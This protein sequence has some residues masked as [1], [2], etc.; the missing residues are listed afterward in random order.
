MSLQASPLNWEPPAAQELLRWP[1][2]YQSLVNRCLVRGVSV[3]ARGR[4]LAMSGLQHVR[5][6]LDPFILAVNHNTRTEA[7]L[8]PALIMLH[9][10]GRQ[11][12]FMAD[13]NFR[14]IPGIGLI[15]RR[16][17]AITVTAK[18][19]RPRVLNTFKPLYRHSRSVLERARFCLAQGKS[20]GIFPEGTINRDP[21]RLLTG[22]RSAAL[23]SLETGVPVVPAGIRFPHAVLDR[24]IRD[25]DPMEVHIGE[26]LYPPPRAE[27]RPQSAALRD[28][29]AAVMSE[30]ARL[31]G[32]SWIP[33]TEAHHES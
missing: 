29:H 27:A 32:K 22:R 21:C 1:L 33:D 4:V 17:G 31:S 12:H 18:P 28:W 5:P 23:L 19:A 2:P 3:L 30:I 8:V 24:P 6:G 20:I 10:G 25:R 15:Y 13:W 16:A 9:R 14:L 26:P 11:I 7:L